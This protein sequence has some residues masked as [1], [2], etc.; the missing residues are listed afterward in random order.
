MRRQI[1]QDYPDAELN[2]AG[3]A[4]HT[5]LAP[6]VQTLGEDAIDKALTALGKRGAAVDAALVVTG[7]KDGE[8]QAMIGSRDPDEPGFN[9]ALDALRP[10]GSLVKPFVYL[11]AL[12]QPQRYSLA[13]LIEDSTI[14]LPQSE[15][16]A[17]AAAVRAARPGIG[18]VGAEVYIDALLARMPD[19]DRAGVIGVL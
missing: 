11:V 13:T 9:R 12:A 4:I 18:R 3:L 19:A 7:A 6:S 15:R 10:I 14:D 1:R 17:L 2:S 8:V 5:T 16:L